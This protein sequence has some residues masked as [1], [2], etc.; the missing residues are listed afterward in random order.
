LSLLLLGLAVAALAALSL[1]RGRRGA[2]L[3]GDARPRVAMAKGPLVLLAYGLPATFVLACCW[4]APVDGTRYRFA[5]VGLGF[6]GTEDGSLEVKIGGDPERNDIALAALSARTGEAAEIGTMVIG[7]AGD[8]RA[9]GGVQRGI[10]LRASRRGVA[11]VVGKDGFEILNRIELAD[12]DRLWLGGRVW[13]VDVKHL[14]FIAEGRGA[15]HS[16]RI[17]IPSRVLK[18]PFVGWPVTES[19]RWL[20]PSAGRST[21]P[22]SWLAADG[23]P[24]RVVERF[25]SFLYLQPRGVVAVLGSLLHL[26]PAESR[27]PRLFLVQ[28]D[29]RVRVER[30]SRRL[31]PVRSAAVAKGERVHVYALPEWGGD[32]FA[33]SGLSERRSFRVEPGRGSAAVLF[34]TPEI[35][36]LNEAQLAALGLRVERGD[37]PSR[38][39]VAVTLGESP[40][41]SSGVHF[42]Q[43]SNRLAGEGVAVVDFAKDRQ[44]FRV[45]GPRGVKEGAMGRPFWIGADRLAA[46]QIDRLTPPLA[47]A[48]LGLVL[49]IAK[50]LAARASR[51]S[52][53][54]VLVGSTLD[55][56]V[57]LRLV[58]AYEAWALPPYREVAMDLA[59]IAWSLIPWAFLAVS[60]PG[61]RAADR[62]PW[63]R[64]LPTIAGCAFSLI[65]CLRLARGW[66]RAA[67]WAACHLVAMLVGWYRAGWPMGSRG[68]R[69]RVALGARWTVMNG[70]AAGERAGQTRQPWFGRFLAW[71]LGRRPPPAEGA[72]VRQLLRHGWAWLRQPWRGSAWLSFTGGRVLLL[73]LGKESV[74]LGGLRF[75]FTLLHVP[76][77]IVYEAAYLVWLWR[78]LRANPAARGVSRLLSIPLGVWLVPAFLV[79]DLGLALVNVPVFLVAAAI[80]ERAARQA[81][82]E[83]RP[84]AAGRRRWAAA[85]ALALLLLGCGC[86]VVAR[87]A[88]SGL[89]ESVRTSWM[90]E[91]NYLR[92]LHFAYPEQLEELAVRPSEDLAT[93]SVVMKAYTA[94]LP[95]IVGHGYLGSEVSPQLRATALREHVPAVLIAGDWGLLGTLGT[96]AI[97]VTLAIL[98][99]SMAPWSARGTVGAGGAALGLRQIESAAGAVAGLTLSVVSLY[100][101]M[102]NYDLLPFTGRNVYLLGLDSTADVLESLELVVLMALG[103]AAWAGGEPVR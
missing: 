65:W 67:V 78:E 43:A 16:L 62:Y 26:E 57:A 33:G 72:A 93:M 99:G 59:L 84:R 24:G 12:G 88:L 94:G 17:E 68:A 87:M 39:R 103:G 30:G 42:R 21:F 4:L 27:F 82:E 97:F 71:R 98:S 48:L 19:V 36:T 54:Q 3:A 89:P 15:G 45:A 90:T 35:V 14:A 86:P 49:A 9:G 60:A 83:R 92:V 38:L 40:L 37:D 20:P 34:E 56:L 55:S 77:A 80:V 18:I 28:L 96:I 1:R 47:L 66:E 76:A 32:G 101:L 46:V 44:S 69:G 25:A 53:E 79:S 7:A 91:R 6:R 73:I 8:G 22:V 63:W 64:L 13:R 85:A 52:V 61:F 100:M 102:T 75:S 81:A 50:A 29:R 74:T 2:P 5:L 51:L 11:G 95:A 70:A 10:E 23:D 31:E 58:L 41:P